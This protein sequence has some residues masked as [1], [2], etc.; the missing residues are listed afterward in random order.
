M[1]A[2]IDRGRRSVARW[3]IL[4]TAS[5]FEYVHNAADDPPIV[6][7]TGTWT[8]AGQERVDS[9]PLPIREPKQVCHRTNSTVSELESLWSVAAQEVNWV[10]SLE[11]VIYVSE[12]V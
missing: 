9:G 3:A 1:K 2:I 4:P 7:T 11:M 8:I 12:K 10:W 6:H 5:R